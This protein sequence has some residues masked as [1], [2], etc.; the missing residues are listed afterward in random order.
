MAA[1]RLLPLVYAGFVMLGIPRA[2]EGVAWPSMAADLDQ[3]LGALGWL[4]AIHITGYF[5]ASIANGPVTRRFGTGRTL[6]VSGMLASASLAG[7]AL[8]PNWEVLLIAAALLGIASGMIDAA[9]N[10]YVALRHGS[11][12]MGFLHASFGVGTTLGPLIITW[13]NT[14]VDGGWRLGFAVFAVMQ[15]VVTVAFWITR[16]RWVLPEAARIQPSSLRIPGLLPLLISFLLVAGVESGTAAW[17]FTYMTREVEI[18]DGPA[19]L[20]VAGFFAS[21]TIGRIGMGI[22]GDRITPATYLVAGSAAALGG[23]AVLW[24]NPAAWVASLGLLVLGLGVAPLFPTLMNITPDIVGTE[25]A[26]NVVGFELGA[27]VIGGAVIPAGIGIAIDA[28]GT[29]TIPVILFGTTIVQFIALRLESSR[30]RA[31]R[32][33]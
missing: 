29:E 19:G 17:A 23:A 22:A 7:Y 1:I 11:R 13:L 6:V 20:I 21:F 26:S 2:A 10:A 12:A 33:A 9:G 5:L 16:E 28:I 8:T 3:R 25:N 14:S 31:V 32:A 18:A 15:A 30:E 24:W 4:I 27:A